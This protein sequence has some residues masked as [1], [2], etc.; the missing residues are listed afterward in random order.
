MTDE[1][2]ANK[3]AFDFICSNDCCT[4]RSAPGIGFDSKNELI[5]CRRSSDAK[6]EVKNYK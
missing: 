4:V 6:S 5:S 1:S 2:R 3:S